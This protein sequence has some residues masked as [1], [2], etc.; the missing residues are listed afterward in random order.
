MP[1][2][3]DLVSTDEE[4]LIFDLTY[5][6]SLGKSEHVSLLLQ[7][8]IKAKENAEELPVRNYYQVNYDKIMK[9][10]GK[11]DW[12]E[13]Y[14]AISRVEAWMYMEAMLLECIKVFVTN[15]EKGEFVHPYYTRMPPILIDFIHWISKRVPFPHSEF[16][17]L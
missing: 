12:E 8:S 14:D 1:S 3:L 5:G 17:S 16:S 13:S 2:T 6:P 15:L 7:S 11:T 4:E 9:V 10:I